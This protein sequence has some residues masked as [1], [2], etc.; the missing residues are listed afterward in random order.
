MTPALQDRVF[1]E[2]DQKM[3]WGKIQEVTDKKIVIKWDS[4]G[5][6]GQSHTT[7]HGNL[8]AVTRNRDC[9]QVKF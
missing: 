2:Y 3:F 9:W 6:I 1:Q 4:F 5:S 7:F 8:S